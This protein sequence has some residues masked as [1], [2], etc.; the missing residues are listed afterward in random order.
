MQ[1]TNP[2]NISQQYSKHIS[3]GHET[4]EEGRTG[5]DNYMESR[6]KEKVEKTFRNAVTRKYSA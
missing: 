5:L 4:R 6:L 1:T 2:H 3:N